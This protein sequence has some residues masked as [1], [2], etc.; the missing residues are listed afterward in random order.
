VL[1]GRTA[2]ALRDE[3]EAEDVEVL[4]MSAGD[5]LAACAQFAET[6]DSDDPDVRHIGQDELD[7]AVAGASWKDTTDGR[8][9]NRRGSTDIC[10]LV[11]VVA[12]RWAAVRQES[13]DIEYDVAASIW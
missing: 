13:A 3:L 2:A 6:M 9:L 4:V 8:T 1:A 7:A 11:S 5:Y 12:A 10:P